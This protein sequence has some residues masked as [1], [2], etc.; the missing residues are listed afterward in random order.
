MGLECPREATS[1]SGVCIANGT[2]RGNTPLVGSIKPEENVHLV[3][4]PSVTPSLRSLKD[5][6]FRSVKSV[7]AGF[8]NVTMELNLELFQVGMVPICRNVL[9]PFQVPDFRLV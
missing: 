8:C 4:C 9:R 6:V 2:R 5:K 1:S 3:A 7:S